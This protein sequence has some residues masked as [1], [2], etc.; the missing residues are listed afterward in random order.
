MSS[1]TPFQRRVYEELMK[2]PRGN[3]ITY[4]ELARRINCKSPQAI[5]QALRVN[6]FAPQVPCHRVIASDGTLGGF[7]GR[8]SGPELARKRV[9]LESEGVRFFPDRRVAQFVDDARRK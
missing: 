2:V 6:P 4:G 1:V 9:L 5:G 8:R 7:N 3:V